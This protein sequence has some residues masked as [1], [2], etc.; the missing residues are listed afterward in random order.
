MPPNKLFFGFFFI[1]ML[2]QTLLGQDE[3]PASLR[4]SE[5]YKIPAN[6]AFNRVISADEDYVYILRESYAAVSKRLTSVIVETYDVKTLKLKRASDIA[7]KYQKK[8]RVFHDIFEINDKFYFIT[9]YFNSAK[10]KNFLFAQRLNVK[11]EPEEA[12][13]LIGEI[14]SRNESKI[15]DFHFE[16]SRDSSKV[17]VYHDLPTKRSEQQESKLSV[18]NDNFELLWDKKIFFPVESKLFD[19]IKFSVDNNGNGYLLGKRYFEKA[20]DK[21]K[22]LP[23]FE[24]VLEVYSEKGESK[25]RYQL[26]DRVKFISDLT[27]EVSK[28][29]EIIC[30]GFYT[31]RLVA[32]RLNTFNDE[33]ESIEGIVYFKIDIEKQVIEEK[34]FTAFD[35]DFITLNSSE[36]QRRK[37]ERRQS[38]NNEFN[39]PQLYSYSFRDVILRSDGG[40]VII[41]EQYYETRFNSNFDNGFNPAF[42]NNTFREVIEYNYNDVI[43]VNINPDGSIRWAN[44]VPKYQSSTQLGEL[45]YFSFANANIQDRIYILFN[46]DRRVFESDSNSIFNS[47]GLKNQALALAEINKTGEL[48]IFML[49]AFD[50]IQSLVLPT[51]TTQIGKKALLIYGEVRN[52]FRVGTVSLD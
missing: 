43:V 16:Q 40:A 33:A 8:L 46:E 22:G 9:S 39:D 44:A 7:L 42:Q 45:K 38:D 6:T 23:N 31:N 24:Y 50:T 1:L 41:A 36:R 10:N 48:N 51:Q 34:K 19:L 29:G 21:V 5:E 52:Y 32:S 4:M 30:T 17:V 20:K 26:K 37:A 15:G 13:I 49:G 18:Y 25:Q 35:L 28:K 27:F 12:L 3:V 14:D 11:F 47:R 2:G